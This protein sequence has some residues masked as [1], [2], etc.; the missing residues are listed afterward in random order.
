MADNNAKQNSPPQNQFYIQ[1][2]YIKDLTFE[3]PHFLMKYSE[4]Q[5]QPSV[6]VNVETVVAK[7]NDNN[8]EVSLDFSVNSKA[9]DKQLFI[10]E[11][12]YGSLVTVASNID[13]EMLEPLLLVHCPFL[14][15]PFARSI[16]S[17]ITN[18]GG[19]PALMIE[20]IDFAS[21][22]IEKKR[23]IQENNTT[24]SVG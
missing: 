17:S 11:L 12:K 7:L 22:Y 19:Y 3:N 6:Q 24:S 13:H 10:L 9:N 18:A 21:M 5:P 20:P 8:Y 14:M 1:D 15:F 2:Q 16:I 4:Q 23:Q